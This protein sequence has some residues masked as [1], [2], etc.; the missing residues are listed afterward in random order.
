[1]RDARS[2][3]GPTIAAI[4]PGPPSD[5]EHG[6]VADVVPTRAVGEGLLEAVAG[7]DARRAIILR[8]REGRDVLPDGLASAASRSTS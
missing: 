2:L 3:A 6:V 7:L 1:M 8:A 5:R 4:G